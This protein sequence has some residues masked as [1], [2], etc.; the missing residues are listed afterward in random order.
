MSD[1]ETSDDPYR[2]CENGYFGQHHVCRKQP[3]EPP[4]VRAPPLRQTVDELHVMNKTLFEILAMLK[5]LA[6]AKR[7]KVM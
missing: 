3:A 6:E 1:K 2:C 4:L 5:I 7:D